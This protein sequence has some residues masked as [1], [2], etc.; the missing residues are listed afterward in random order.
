LSAASGVGQQAACSPAQA[1]A[2]EF[3]TPLNGTNTLIFDGD[4]AGPSCPT[5]AAVGLLELPVSDD[6]DALNQDPPGHVDPNNDGQLDATVF[7][8]LA[9]GSPS[10][11][12]LGR[13]P[14]D[15][16][17]TAGASPGL[18]A[19]RQLLGLGL[20]DDVDAL[21]VIDRGVPNLY[22]AGIDTVLFS[23]A[24]GSPALGDFG[25]SAADILR[26]GPQ[27]AHAASTLGLRSADDLDALACYD[28]DVSLPTPTPPAT[29]TPAGA[30]GDAN[31]SGSVNSIDAAVVLQ[32]TAGLVGSVPCPALADV[33]GD[34]QINSLDAAL[35][36]QF[37]AGLLGHLPP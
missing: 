8:S 34:G 35:I 6:L 20:G 11:A 16:M 4:G 15:I 5:A 17:W 2:D 22:E 14:G 13:S 32:R 25:L 12:L 36:L 18:Y 26:P 21:C 33:N 7:F 24:A 1:Q 29:P 10:L 31:C 27:Q 3:S 19:S 30:A 37:V 28:Y 9:T 23:L